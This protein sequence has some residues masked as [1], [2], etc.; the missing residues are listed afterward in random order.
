VGRYGMDASGSGQVMIGRLRGCFLGHCPYSIPLGQR[1]ES[2]Y[3][4][5][6]MIV[7]LWLASRSRWCSCQLM[8]AKAEAN[9][10]CVCAAEISALCSLN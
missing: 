7:C 6:Q 9:G 2:C 1:E 3:V 5:K 4:A 8:K 10:A